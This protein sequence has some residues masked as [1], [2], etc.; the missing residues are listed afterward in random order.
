VECDTYQLWA[1]LTNHERVPARYHAL[2]PMLRPSAWPP[3]HRPEPCRDCDGFAPQ[4]VYLA[5]KTPKCIAI[6]KTHTHTNTIIFARAYTINNKFFHFDRYYEKLA[7]CQYEYNPDYTSYLK[8]KCEEDTFGKFCIFHDKERYVENEYKAV[9]RFEQKVSENKG[10]LLKCIGYYLPDIDFAKLFK[11]FQVSVYF[12]KA[13]FYKG[14][15][16]F[17][18]MFSPFSTIGCCSQCPSA[19][20][21][22]PS[23]CFR[24]L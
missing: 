13:T 3:S 1:R 5:L 24:I 21:V 7:T 16:F 19:F 12:S 2:E 14:A 18:V 8:F 22:V 15:N 4:R 6:V 17:K 10:K 9:R 23:L 20:P 11:G